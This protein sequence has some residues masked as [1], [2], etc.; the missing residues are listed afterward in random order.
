VGEDGHIASLFPNSVAIN[1]ELK[2]VYVNDSPKWP[3]ERYTITRRVI[4]SARNVIVMAA[5]KKKGNVLTRSLEDPNNFMELP[6]RLT[7]GRTWVLDKAAYKS[8]EQ[9]KPLNI[10]NT[11][12]IHE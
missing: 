2:F 4:Q 10:L 9:K 7:I 8:F 3:S 11:R 5:G 1:N 6:V 12:I